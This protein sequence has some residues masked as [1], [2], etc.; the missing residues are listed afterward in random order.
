MY[1]EFKWYNLNPSKAIIS[2][3]FVFIGKLQKLYIQDTQMIMVQA[4]NV[5]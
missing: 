4:H 1:I 5:K 3:S 2:F